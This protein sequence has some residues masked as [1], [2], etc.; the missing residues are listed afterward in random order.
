MCFLAFVLK[1][2][3]QTGQPGLGVWP[4]NAHP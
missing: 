1:T 3:S 4:S 2:V